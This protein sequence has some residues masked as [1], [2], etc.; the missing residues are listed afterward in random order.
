MI[1]FYRFRKDSSNESN[2]KLLDFEE[3]SSKVNCLIMTYP[4][5]FNM[6]YS[7]ILNPMIKQSWLIQDLIKDGNAKFVF[8]LFQDLLPFLIITNYK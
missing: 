4:F 7:R 3:N 1:F 5:A 6:F 2:E 8:W